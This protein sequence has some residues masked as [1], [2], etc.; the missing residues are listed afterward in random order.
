SSAPANFS[1]QK[2]TISN[3]TIVVGATGSHQK[4]QTY[5]NVDLEAE[6]LSYTSQF[7]FKFS[8]K[9]PGDGSVKLEGKA[10]PIDAADAALTPLDAKIDVQHFDIAAAGV[11]DPSAGIA[12]VID[13]TGNLASDGH[14]MTSAGAVKA[15]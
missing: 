2:L 14:Q 12:G 4:N 5:Q 6:A 10:G 13:F 8:A 3:G 9:T 15:T 7:P 1:V 11:V